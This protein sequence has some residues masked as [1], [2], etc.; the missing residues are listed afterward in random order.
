MISINLAQGD[1]KRRKSSC[2]VGSTSSFQTYEFNAKINR[3]IRS[4]VVETTGMTLKGRRRSGYATQGGLMFVFG[5]FDGHKYH[6]DIHVCS[7]K[8]ILDEILGIPRVSLFNEGYQPP[9]SLREVSCI[10]VYCQQGTITIPKFWLLLRLRSTCE[11]LQANLS[12]SN[13]LFLTNFSVGQAEDFFLRILR[14]EWGSDRTFQQISAAL[15]LQEHDLIKRSDVHSLEARLKQEG[16][17]SATRV[18][19]TGMHL[20]LFID[21]AFLA[22]YSSF[23][24]ENMQFSADCRCMN[25]EHSMDARFLSYIKLTLEIHFQLESTCLDVSQL[26]DAWQAADYLVAPIVQQVS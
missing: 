24:R 23:F 12:K 26:I 8:P 11:Q 1:S 18:S 20:D 4:Q 5:G 10:K 13:T 15:N 9:F 16:D 17:S 2:A 3:V 7:F 25:S 14:G 21:Q 22:R 6:S 19:I